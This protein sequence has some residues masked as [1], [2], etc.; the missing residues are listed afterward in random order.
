MKK[1]NYHEL[2]EMWLEFYKEHGHQIIPSASLVPENDGSV[3]FTT[4]GMHPLVPY[5]LGEKHP[6]GKRLANIQK[7]VRTKDIE[8]V[9]NPSHLTFF[10]MMGNWSLG[11]YFK[12]EKI[13]WSFEFLT[14]PK[15]LNV[16]KDLISVTCFAGDEDAPR[17]EESAKCWEKVG[18]P[19][20]RIW[21]L[22][23]SENW[24][25]LD[26]GGPCG[27]C[28]EMFLDTKKKKCGDD[29]NPSCSCGKYIEVGNDV[30]MEYVSTNGKIAK[31]SQ[32]N[33]DTGM[34]L[35]RM[36]L[37]CNGLKSVYETEI[38]APALKIIGE[39]S[40]ASRIIAEHTRAAMFIISDAVIPGNSGAGY[41]LRRLIRRA[42]RM[43][44]KLN[45]TNFEILIDSYLPTYEK[46]YTLNK[47]QILKIFM[48]EVAKFEKTLEQGIK[49]FEK[50]TKYATDGKLNGKTAFRLY[51]TYGFPIELTQELAKEAGLSINM[52]EYEDAK[53]KH[54]AL[55]TTASA[56]AFK[57]GL[58]DT[59]N[60]TAQLHTATHLLLAILREIYG[61]KVFQKGSNITPERLRFDFNIDHKL[62]AAEITEIEKRVNACIKQNLKI[63][64]QETNLESAK[65]LG[66]V[67]SFADKYG[68]LVKVYSI[69]NVS[70]EICGGPH[71]ENTGE[72]G[73]FKIIKEESVSA[74]I[75]RIKAVL[76][77]VL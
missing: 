7:C 18:I 63:K 77:N 54:A 44:R 39:N 40:E 58:A 27:P 14:S 29:C 10:E 65:K 15:Y 5:L 36:L 56:G 23:K 60:A 31:A 17:D 49:E 47:T 19:K 9:G 4:A 35:E 64:V 61:E 38:F 70:C 6:A 20:E 12:K 2:R 68:E 22:P 48:D 13:A 3:L 55:S 51:D 8:C 71:A 25:G 11:D 24:W 50:V 42:V 28:S 16:D 33:V 30:Y 57:G 26:T 66:A 75:R 43:A 67:G 59:T 41:V 46:Y 73:T 72:L 53:A 62:D 52:Q 76:T 1:L 45:F 37:M 32:H 34:G 69:G 74:G 21:F